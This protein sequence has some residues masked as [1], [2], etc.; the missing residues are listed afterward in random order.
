MVLD[1]KK[2]NRF[3]EKKNNFVK[4]TKLN[5]G[6]I[7]EKMRVI[8]H[9]GENLGVLTREEAILNAQQE[10]LDLVL[11]SEPSGSGKGEEVLPVA[12]II[13]YSKKLYEEKKKN[14]KNKKNSVEFKNK[15]VKFGPSTSDHDL[16]YKLV[17]VLN[18]LLSGHRV[19]ITIVMRG[20]ERQ[21][22]DSHAIPMMEK[23]IEKVETMVYE[24]K[25]S[26]SLVFEKHFVGSGFIFTL[27]CLKR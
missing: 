15:E 10:N 17:Q 6:I 5:D 3:F 16:T 19:K 9:S 27:F 22:K 14:H 8:S 26:K 2:K 20:R 4:N 21:K 1:K 18:F 12:K 11:V 23:I 25:I 13:D 7:H 24:K